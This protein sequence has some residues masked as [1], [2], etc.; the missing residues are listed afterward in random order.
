MYSAHKKAGKQK[1]QCNFTNSSGNYGNAVF[2]CSTSIIKKLLENISGLM[3]FSKQMR[4]KLP[5][6]E[7]VLAVWGKDYGG[8]NFP[9]GVRTPQFIS[10]R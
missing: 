1:G 5:F 4:G 10:C 6:F 9:K 2:S 8:K 7:P 3:L